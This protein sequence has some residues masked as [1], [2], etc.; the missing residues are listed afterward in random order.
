[1]AITPRITQPRGTDGNRRKTYGT[2]NL[3]TYAT[4]GVAFTATMVGL[5]TVDFI[6]FEEVASG[7]RLLHDRTNSKIKAL[8]A[9][10]TEVPN[11]TDLSVTP[12][13]I[14]YMAV[15]R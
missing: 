13:N 5:K 7:H 11:A 4:N 1:M 14:R 15:G 12:G 8:V 10:G 3:N 6:V 9:A 2:L